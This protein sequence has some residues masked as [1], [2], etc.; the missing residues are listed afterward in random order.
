MLAA[1]AKVTSVCICGETGPKAPLANTV[2]RCR[3]AME[4]ERTV[5]WRKI[6]VSKL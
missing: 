4:K 1:N 6:Q 3:T 5:S 2:V